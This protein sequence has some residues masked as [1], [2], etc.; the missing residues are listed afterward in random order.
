MRTLQRPSSISAAQWA[1]ML[2]QLATISHLL[3]DKLMRA[4]PLFSEERSLY[5]AFLTLPLR[6]DDFPVGTRLIMPM[7]F[8]RRL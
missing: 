2:V 5:D 4:D 3:L 1:Q 7:R 6:I 8:F